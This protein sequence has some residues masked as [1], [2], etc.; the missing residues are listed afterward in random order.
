MK[1]D[2]SESTPQGRDTRQWV[3][4]GGTCLSSGAWWRSS[5]GWLGRV[6]FWFFDTITPFRWRFSWPRLYSSAVFGDFEQ[7]PLPE[8]SRRPVEDLILQMK[9]LNIEKVSGGPSPARTPRSFPH[10]VS[11]QLPTGMAGSRDPLLPQDCTL[12]NI[13]STCPRHRGLL[14]STGFQ[15]VLLT[16]SSGDSSILTM[17][18]SGVPHLSA[19]PG[20]VVQADRD[21]GPVTSHSRSFLPN[22]ESPWLCLL[23]TFHV[24]GVIPIDVFSGHPYGGMCPHFSP[25]R[26]SPAPSW[27]PD[28]YCLAIHLSMGACIVTTCGHEC[29]SSCGHECV[30]IC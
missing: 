28:M 5:A 11:T 30:R 27:G 18:L 2:P 21:P 24:N 23:W 10:A 16:Q 3:G 12:P 8:I 13:Q 26:L 20:S 15:N 19:A 17:P 14:L 29:Q 25:F 6:P 1:A 7:F 9:A 22:P 4:R